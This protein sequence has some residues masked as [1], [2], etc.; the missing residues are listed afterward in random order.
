MKWSYEGGSGPDHWAKLCP[1]FAPCAEGKNQSPVDISEPVKAGPGNIVFGYKKAPITIH[2]NG[3]NVL[4][5]TP[6]CGWMKV[7]GGTFFPDHFHFHCPGEHTF[8]GNSHDLELHLVHK[9]AQDNLAVVGVLFRRG[10]HNRVIQLLWDAVSTGGNR[11][12]TSGNV[13]LDVSELL[14]GTGSYYYFHGSLTTPPCTE[15]V[16]WFVMKTALEV[17]DAQVQ[18][19]LSLNGPNA[20]PVQPLNGRTVYEYK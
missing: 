1:G 20:R 17:S 3:F 18:W 12:Q 8:D 11:E 19:F 6:G 13:I 5:E 7:G 2:D 9:D 10:T 14:P 15:G 4:F 16:K